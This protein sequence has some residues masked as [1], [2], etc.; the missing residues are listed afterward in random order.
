MLTQLGR[1]DEARAVLSEALTIAENQG[2]DPYK[3]LLGLVHLAN[4]ETSLIERKFAVA[5]KEGDLALSLAGIDFKS[6]A[7]RGKSVV[8]LARA[9]SGQ[10]GG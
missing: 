9:L 7:V 8:G 3:E 1:A 6:I 4:A 2:K 5:I 10:T